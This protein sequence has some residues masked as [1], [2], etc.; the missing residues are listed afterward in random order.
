MTGKMMDAVEKAEKGKVAEIH[1]KTTPIILPTEGETVEANIKKD[2]MIYKTLNNPELLTHV[3]LPELDKK[4]V[5]EKNNK[6]TSFL[7]SG[8]RLVLNGN[9]TS[10]NTMI[11]SES[12]SGKDFI[13]REA[14]KLWGTDIAITRSRISETALTYWHNA[15][16]EPE[17]TWD[18]KVLY[19]SDVSNDILNS[20]VIKQ[21]MSDDVEST[22]TVD[23][24]AK[25]FKINGKPVMFLSSASA[26]VGHEL[27]R[28]MP[29]MTLDESNDQTK[30]IIKRQLVD[31][32]RPGWSRKELEYDKDVL[33]ALSE[34]KQ[35]SVIIPYAEKLEKVFGDGL[36]MRTVVSRFLDYIRASAALHQAQR[37]REDTEVLAEG[38][39]YDNAVMMLKA[40]T[41]NPAMIPLTKK[42]Q[43]IL[44][45]FPKDESIQVSNLLAK[46]TFCAEKTLRKELDRLS[47]HGFLKKEVDMYEESS[48]KPV[49]LYK[50]IIQ[51]ELKIPSW[52][53][54]GSYDS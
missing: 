12:G 27:L 10:F 6:L 17:W 32:A 44:K 50:L 3:I 5:G 4:I 33:Q 28:R 42:Q 9:K 34:L 47:H 1:K 45:L 21:Y 14:L 20:E 13:L 15:K 30:K 36:I 43:N 16:D 11:N 52:K 40:T 35:V 46:V 37:K 41:C 53:E 29:I 25:D 19:L 8:G 54:L 24:K 2:K 51:E 23:N 38:Q 48:K 26:T 18:S 7:I 31:A 22:I 39:D 49:M